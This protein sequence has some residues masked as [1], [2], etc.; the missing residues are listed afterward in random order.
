MSKIGIVTVLYNSE[1][2]L[3]DFFR[4]LDKQSYKDFTL[5][6]VDNASTDNGLSKSHELAST[7][8]FK[9]IFIEE[10]KNWGIAKGNNIGIKAA[11]Y[12]GCEYILLSNNDVVLNCDDTIEILKKRIEDSD[13]DIITPKIKKYS[14]PS[15]IW[16]AGGEFRFFGTKT[17]HIGANC[18]DDGRYDKELI[19]N[20]TPTC[21]VLIKKN[22]IS[23]I[24]LMDENF[25]VYFDDTDFIY[26][27]L[28]SGHRIVYTPVTEILH[29]E[30]ASTGKMSN[31]KIYQ[32]SKN[33]II[34]TQK[35]FSR[36]ILA[37]LLARNWIIHFTYHRIKFNRE[38]LD[39]EYKGF[40]DGLKFIKG[41]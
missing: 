34:Y 23:D 38:Q 6:I 28:K 41:K 31:F 19:I 16:A 13:I 4:T 33:Q 39:A 32:L 15:E 11:L 21:F 7:V 24:G 30:S 29:N 10:K 3:D 1:S 5:Y 9:C 27:A 35:N 25:F 2:V 12:D 26:R 40:K 14:N 18:Q 37:L 17:K 20:Y 36:F 22:V 8:S